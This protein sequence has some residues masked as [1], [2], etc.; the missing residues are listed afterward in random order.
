MHLRCLSPT[1]ESH[2][3]SVFPFKWSALAFTYLDIQIPRDLCSIYTVNYLPLLRS[4]QQLLLDWNKPY[5]SWFGR[6][7]ILKMMILPKFLYLLQSV[8]TEIP[9]PYFASI[10]KMFTKFLWND[11]KAHN[12]ASQLCKPKH[13][14]GIGLPEVEAYYYVC[15]AAQ[16]VDWHVDGLIQ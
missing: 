13:L 4:V 2:C 9:A 14:G 12:N 5:F 10:R 6:A 15:Q 3:P 11:C 16:V 8:P 1:L 7:A